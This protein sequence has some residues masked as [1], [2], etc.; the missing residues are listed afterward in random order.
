MVNPKYKQGDGVIVTNVGVGIICSEPE[1]EFDDEA[2]STGD[3]TYLVSFN[4]INDNGWFGEKEMEDYTNSHRDID[5][6]D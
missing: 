3:W 4:E 5:G 2:Q 6:Q 1:Y